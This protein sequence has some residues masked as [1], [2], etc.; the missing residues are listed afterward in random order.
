MITN[1][2]NNFRFCEK[3]EN[4]KEK[5]NECH[6]TESQRKKG[7]QTRNENRRRARAAKA[8]SARSADKYMEGTVTFSE[9]TREGKRAKSETEN[10][11]GVEGWRT[12]KK[13]V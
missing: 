5:R 11:T 6:K 3:C 4:S 7:D 9:K 12:A 13:R 1:V 10:R 8:R 2:K